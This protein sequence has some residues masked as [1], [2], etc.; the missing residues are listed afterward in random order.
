[1]TKAIETKWL[2]WTNTKPRRI[3]AFAEGGNRHVQGESCNDL[4]ALQQEAA[5][6]YALAS[7]L[8]W[9]GVWIAGTLANGNTVFVNVGRN[10]AE[11]DTLTT[12]LAGLQLGSWFEIVAKGRA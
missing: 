2:P 9:A 1:M 11:L 5:A 10:A 6:A 12:Y 3:C 7:R 4:S 8:D